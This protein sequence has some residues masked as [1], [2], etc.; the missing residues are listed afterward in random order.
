MPR[1]AVATAAAAL[2]L[3]A[4]GAAEAQ[5]PTTVAALDRTDAAEGTPDLKRVAATRGADRGVR[6]AVS[7]AAPLVPADLLTDADDAGPPGS[8]CVRLWTVSTPRSTPPDLLACVTSQA[9][10][11]TLRG[12][13]SKEVPGALPSTV[14]S[15]TPTRPSRTSVALRLPSSLFT[16]VRR[17][18]FAGEATRP[19][20]VRLG[21][22]DL[23]PDLGVVKSLTLR[24]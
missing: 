8:I 15:V 22:T 1:L 23:A 17:V 2:T 18:R 14:A 5:A 7:L 9:D 16:G 21:C 19:G 13:V 12:T 3:L 11:K 24:P 4:T 10:G 6:L 20:C